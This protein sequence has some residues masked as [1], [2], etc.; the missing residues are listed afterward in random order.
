MHPPMPPPPPRRVAGLPRPSRVS[1]ERK[2]DDF[3]VTAAAAPALLPL[4]RRPRVPGAFGDAEAEPSERST[5]DHF[6]ERTDY[7]KKTGVDAEAV[8][9]L[10]LMWR[11]GGRPVLLRPDGVRPRGSAGPGALQPL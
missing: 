6:F 1:F 8:L 4:L 11:T 9:C 10:G 5:A 2:L 7:G 3:T